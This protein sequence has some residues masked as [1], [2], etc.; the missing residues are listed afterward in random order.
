MG[1]DATGI[2]IGDKIEKILP[3]HGT[4]PRSSPPSA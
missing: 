3:G 4:A 2:K 1:S